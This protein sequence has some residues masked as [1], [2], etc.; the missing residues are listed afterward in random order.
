MKVSFKTTFATRFEEMRHT[1]TFWSGPIR[2]SR[3]TTSFTSMD[4]FDADRECLASQLPRMTDGTHATM[5]K[6]F[7]ARLGTASVPTIVRDKGRS[8]FMLTYSS[9]CI[10]A[11]RVI[12]GTPTWVRHHTLY[13]PPSS[14]HML[15]TAYQSFIFTIVCFNRN[16]A[17]CFHKGIRLCAPRYVREDVLTLQW[18][19]PIIFTTYAV[20]LAAR[21]P[22]PCLEAL[23]AIK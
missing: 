4:D 23:T 15:L 2:T 14:L 13:I 20:G 12:N 19:N 22:K 5:E 21:T 18:Q 3:F 9:P 1:A 8:F 11:Q 17:L 10:C 6:S 16:I 7:K